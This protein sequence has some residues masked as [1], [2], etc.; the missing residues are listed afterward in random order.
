M[1]QDQSGRLQPG[2]QR[3]DPAE[4]ERAGKYLSRMPVSEDHEGD[5]RPA[6]PGDDIGRKHVELRD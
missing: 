6:S 2:L 4:D 3:I 1:R 5:R